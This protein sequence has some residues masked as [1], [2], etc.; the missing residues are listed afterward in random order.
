MFGSGEKGRKE[1]ERWKRLNMF[2]SLIWYAYKLVGMIEI[3]VGIMFF[4]SLPFEKKK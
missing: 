4:F 2:P 1:K 3:Y